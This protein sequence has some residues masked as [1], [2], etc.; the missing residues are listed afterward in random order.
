MRL[1]K[2]SMRLE[3]IQIQFLKEISIFDMC[4]ATNTDANKL[5]F[6]SKVD[7]QQSLDNPPECNSINQEN[8]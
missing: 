5:V 6:S 8:P 2:Q 1:E 7:L 3:Q 4:T